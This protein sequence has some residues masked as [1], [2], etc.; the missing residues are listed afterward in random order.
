[1]IADIN[2]QNVPPSTNHCIN[3]VTSAV[4]IVNQKV[5]IKSKAKQTPLKS[6]SSEIVMSWSQHVTRDYVIR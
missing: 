3:Q 4:K 2:K 5:I 1:M 6:V